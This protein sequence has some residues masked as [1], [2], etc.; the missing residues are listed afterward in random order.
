MTNAIGPRLGSGKEAEV[1]A[2][3]GYALKLYRHPAAKPSAFREAATLSIIECLGLPAPRPISVGAFGDRWGV[4]MTRADGRPFAEALPGDPA[5]HLAAMA[6]LHARIHACDAS[7]LPA[8]K[9]RL[10]HDIRQ[11]ELLGPARRRT[12]LAALAALPDGDR[13]CHGDFHPWNI[14]GTPEAP[15]VID[16]LDATRGHP[17][18]DLC[19]SYVLIHPVWPETARAYLTVYDAAAPGETEDLLAWLPVVAGARLA[20]GSRR[21]LLRS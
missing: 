20:E 7:R 21:R 10:A 3:E 9:S 12:L 5:P 6:R 8:L 13:L 2:Y 1:F 17:T 14:L 16:W 19:R 4:V 18:A 11:A 15:M